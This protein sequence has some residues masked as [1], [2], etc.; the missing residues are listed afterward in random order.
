VADALT[1][2]LVQ[3]LEENGQKIDACGLLD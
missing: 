1:G 2:T 3:P